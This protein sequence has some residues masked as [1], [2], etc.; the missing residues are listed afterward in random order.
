MKSV[1]KVAVFVV[2]A[3][4]QIQAQFPLLADEDGIQID[5]V[6]R[7][8]STATDHDQEL[9]NYAKFLAKI[10]SY[11]QQKRPP[12]RPPPIGN[13]EEVRPPIRPPISREE[14][15]PAI[16]PPPA[17]IGNSEEMRPPIRPPIFREELRPPIR[18]PPIGNSEEV[19]PPIRPPIYREELRPPIRP[20][21]IGN[22]EE[23]RPPIRPPIS[24]GDNE[25]A[26]DQTTALCPTPNCT[27]NV[28]L[29]VTH[30][31]IRDTNGRPTDNCTIHN[32]PYCD[33]VCF[34]SYRYRIPKLTG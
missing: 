22:S 28:S 9:L 3:I 16:R 24:T 17:P 20:P 15:R 13:S 18:L 33:G 8:D 5:I 26:E 21:P 7:V 31:F 34:S 25:M 27:C 30:G 32:V 6:G 1:I 4:N 29:L 10:S 12:I 19:R 2:L 23:M 14:M 11:P